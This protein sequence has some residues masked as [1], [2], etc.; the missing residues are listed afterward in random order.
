MSVSAVNG[1]TFKYPIIDDR[2]NHLDG[3]MKNNIVFDYIVQALSH[4]TDGN[5]LDYT[6]SV[7]KLWKD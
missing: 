3:Q 4:Y 2:P 5:L 6:E 1:N 7:N